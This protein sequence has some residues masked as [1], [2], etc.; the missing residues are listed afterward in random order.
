MPREQTIPK[1][2]MMNFLSILIGILCFCLM[3]IGLIPFLGLLQ[4]VVMAG[5]VLGI[6]FGAISKEKPGLYINVAVLAVA[7]VR[8]LAGGGVV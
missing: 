4:W 7:I 3:A 8:S 2:A 5:S 1:T 6:I